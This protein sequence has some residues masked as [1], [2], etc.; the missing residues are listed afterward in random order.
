[1][2]CVR[3]LFS[4]RSAACLG[5]IIIGFHVINIRL[6]RSPNISSTASRGW[7]PLNVSQST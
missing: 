2:N 6:Q 7:L 1:M 5:P 3:R 4:V